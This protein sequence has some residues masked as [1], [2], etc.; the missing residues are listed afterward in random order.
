MSIVR[1]IKDDRQRF[2]ITDVEIHENTQ[3]SFG[4]RGLHAYL[5]SKP[6]EW[7][8][9]MTDLINASPAGKDA[10]RRMTSELEL[11]GY[12]HRN[13]T[14]D[15]ETGKYK[16]ISNVY[17]RVD[18]NPEYTPTYGGNGSEE[19]EPGRE[20]RRGPGRVS[21]D[22]KPAP[23]VKIDLNNKNI[24]GL[25][26]FETG[27]FL[28]ILNDL[29]V[30][31]EEVREMAIIL[32]DTCKGFA[33]FM[34][35]GNC[36]FHAASVLLI[37]ANISKEQVTA[38]IPWWEENGYYVGQPSIKSLMDEVENSIKGV[39]KIKARKMPETMTALGEVEDWMARRIK[40]EDFSSPHTLE[41]IRAVG[42]SKIRGMT[43]NNRKN[44]LAEFERE[45]ERAKQNA[46]TR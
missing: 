34:T 7:T 38:F 13:K 1:V 14:H 18:L 27:S 20:T 29:G 32:G 3:L 24:G 26:N 40:V 42:E 16:T 30:D 31:S 25:L 19:S 17:E 28:E 39:K 33:N 35:P 22:G 45:F 9:R 46:Q 36:D 4:A 2:L 23:L 21:R 41:A 43:T 37:K 8:V 10:V 12:L 11:A 6:P 44:V 5:M 15:P